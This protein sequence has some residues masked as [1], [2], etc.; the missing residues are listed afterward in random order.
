VHPAAGVV[1]SPVYTIRSLEL[2]SRR[3]AT[4]MALDSIFRAAAHLVSKSTPTNNANEN[5]ESVLSARLSKYYTERGVLEVN[6]D[7]TDL[8]AVQL[9]TA[10]E[11]LFVA[12][13]VHDA[14]VLTEANQPEKAT[15]QTEIPVFGTR[16]VSHLRTLV[17]IVFKWG[18]D[19]LLDRVVPN[20]TSASSSKAQGFASVVD[21]TR[22]P[23]D[24]KELC[25]LTYHVLSIVLPSGHR[26]Q[27]SQSFVANLLLTR[28][29][30][31]ILKPCITLGW[32]P[33]AL[34]TPSIPVQDDIRSLTMRLLS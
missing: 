16:D 8:S 20:W 21:L 2:R 15:M 4:L 3:D 13:Q 18:T 31:D 12:Q 26:G 28:H 25:D 19:P 32:L 9:Q 34:S 33:K 10:K 29:L 22:G 5:L 11:A 7:K 1:T 24:Y 6:Y 27:L 23:E 17:S 14:L 30:G